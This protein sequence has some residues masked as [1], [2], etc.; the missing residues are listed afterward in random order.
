MMKPI[1]S[2]IV[3]CLKNSNSNWFNCI[4]AP[5]QV[6]QLLCYHTVG[7]HLHRKNLSAMQQVIHSS[8][9]TKTYS[10]LLS[11]SLLVGHVPIIGVANVYLP[12]H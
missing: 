2:K 8:T 12:C 6:T 4:A 10:F 1:C 3:M 9:A 5:T 11:N 7:C